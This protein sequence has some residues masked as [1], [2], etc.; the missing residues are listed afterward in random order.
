MLPV[1]SLKKPAIS[2]MGKKLAM[3]EPSR[4]QFIWIFERK[5]LFYWNSGNK[6]QENARSIATHP[7]HSITLDT[8]KKREMSSVITEK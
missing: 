1:K 2:G 4:F 6:V 5:L 3:E 7:L 8:M